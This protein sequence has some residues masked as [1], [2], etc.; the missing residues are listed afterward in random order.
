[1]SDIIVYCYNE[2]ETPAQIEKLRANGHQVVLRQN[3]IDDEKKECQLLILGLDAMPVEDDASWK[4]VSNLAAKAP[5]I[6]LHANPTQELC[7]AAAHA[8]VSLVLPHSADQDVFLYA[9]EQLLQQY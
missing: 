6:G 1:M 2:K 4:I 5:V 9:A 3:L 8:K 7:Q